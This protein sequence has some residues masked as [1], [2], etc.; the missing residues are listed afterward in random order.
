MS[1]SIE[2][3]NDS[4]NNNSNAN[5]TEPS[6]STDKDDRQKLTAPSNLSVQKFLNQQNEMRALMKEKE[7][8][9]PQM[10]GMNDEIFQT[11]DGP[12]A[13]ERCHCTYRNRNS[14]ERH[15]GTCEIIATTSESDSESPMHNDNSIYMTNTSQQSTI[16]GMTNGNVI[17][18]I[19]QQ[20]NQ[21]LA[22]SIPIVINPFGQAGNGGNLQ[23][24]ITLSNGMQNLQNLSLTLNSDGNLCQN[25]IV[26]QQG[27]QI[28]GQ[29]INLGNFGQGATLMPV[30]S[31][32]QATSNVINNGNI[33]YIN[34]SQQQQQQPQYISLAPASNNGSN[35][36]QQMM[37]FTSQ[38]SSE[39]HH[40]DQKMITS[41]S[42]KKLILPSPIKSKSK[43]PGM[44]SGT[45]VKQQTIMSNGKKK[46]DIQK[47]QISVMN[48]KNIA[49]A[50]YQ[51]NRQQQV[52]QQPQNII[53]QQPQQ[54]QQLNQYPLILNQN[55]QLVQY[56]TS[57]G[58]NNQ[59]Q[60]LSG[61]N[62]G[63]DVNKQQQQYIQPQ[64]N[65]QFLQNSFQLPTNNGG[66]LVLSANGL[67]VLPVVPQSQVIGTLIQQ[68]QGL[69]CGGLMSAEQMMLGSTPSLEMDPTSGCMYLT[70]QPLYYGLET[71]VQNT[72]MS[73][74]Q[75]VST[76]MQGVL[77]QNSSYS[78]TTTQVF[79]ASKIEPI[80]ELPQGYVFLNAGDNMNA[81]T[82]GIHQSPINM[83]S[84]NI[85]DDKKSVESINTFIPTPKPSNI[86]IMKQQK[87]KTTTKVNKIQP[88]IVSKI[89][90]AS[91]VATTNPT[92]TYNTVLKTINDNPVKAVH[93]NIQIMQASPVAKKQKNTYRTIGPKISAMSP[94]AVSDGIVKTQA[95][96]A[97]GFIK[98]NKI[99]SKPI[100]NNNNNNIIVPANNTNYHAIPIKPAVTI[101]TVPAVAIS[102]SSETDITKV[103]I[104]QTY[105][106]VQSN[107]IAI[108]TQKVVEHPST[109][110][111]STIINIPTNVVNPMQ[112]PPP[113]QNSIFNNL[114]T[115][116]ST[117]IKNHFQNRPTNRVLPMQVIGANGAI[118]I[119]KNSNKNTSNGGCG[120][121]LINNNNPTLNTSSTTPALTTSTTNISSNSNQIVS[122]QLQQLQQQNELLQETYSEKIKSIAMELQSSKSDDLFD[123]LRRQSIATPIPSDSLMDKNGKKS[124]TSCAMDNYLVPS[125]S[126]SSI[127]SSKSPSMIKTTSSSA[128]LTKTIDSV[129]T[130]ANL[131]EHD[132]VEPLD[133]EIQEITEPI[134]PIIITLPTEVIEEQLEV[135]EKIEENDE[136]LIS[137][138]KMY[139]EL[140]ELKPPLIA[141]ETEDDTNAMEANENADE[142]KESEKINFVSFD[143]EMSAVED[144]PS[145]SAGPSFTIKSPNKPST[146]VSSNKIC[147]PKILYEIQSQDGFTYKSTSIS[148][149]WE[150]LFETV[151]CARKAHGLMPLPEG[152]LNEMTGDQMLGLKTNALKYLLEQLP[153]VEKCTRYSP[154]YH[155]RNSSASSSSSVSLI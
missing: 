41:Q 48:S 150:K 78:A 39:I 68:P 6:K 58:Q 95:T 138:E 84:W 105:R 81:N 74:Q 83:D 12:V 80:M 148:E 36:S 1:T 104:D 107:T 51:Q 140:P 55:G 32:S 96:V 139:E 128:S 134:H 31:F 4:N 38:Q 98:P 118:K 49:I 10:D 126:A 46:Q 109:S 25:V 129:A 16:T 135:T 63:K 93:Q 35:S 17:S 14:Y 86:A 116:H 100:Q 153:G 88:Q 154:K 11:N 120:N 136:K 40:H 122:Q 5:T 13:C 151:Q 21:Q 76:A 3:N 114:T 127:T 102:K 53:F 60:Y 45:L 57:D 115:K 2:N 132:D 47:Q 64:N 144:K 75:F 143:E 29:P 119:A 142:I 89:I 101:T 113:Q 71:I 155:Q 73:S 125:T 94:V 52:T 15:L 28:Y 106:N 65:Q 24:S 91:S 97:A 37:T 62:G 145:T 22:N 69:Q 59:I 121:N 9:I 33:S 66:N 111:A 99:Q 108:K 70:S 85:V 77:S 130:G 92:T 152:R 110:Q 82:N 131:L 18:M 44:S 72:V 112:Q 123:S 149:I 147:G 117:T 7:P 103:A 20:Q 30:R 42:N 146:T 8:K 54:Q 61:M 79:Q 26:D 90:P 50:N 43:S 19:N 141:T 27:Q 23:N 56:Y 87:T 137:I 133:V 34:T 124:P 67:S